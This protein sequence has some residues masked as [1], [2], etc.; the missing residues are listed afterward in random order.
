MITVHHG[1]VKNEKFDIDRI[2]EEN[3]K[4]SNNV[5]VRK[6]DVKVET[7][8]SDNLYAGATLSS[9]TDFTVDSDSMPTLSNFIDTTKLPL[10]TSEAN[11][12]LLTTTAKSLDEPKKHTVIPENKIYDDD[13]DDSF[14]DFSVEFSGVKYVR[15][16]KFRVHTSYQ[17]TALTKPLV[18]GFLATVGYPKFY[19][20]DSECNWKISAPNGQKIRLTILDLNLRSESVLFFVWFY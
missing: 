16:N 4:K 9:K 15:K 19:V 13:E 5:I 1:I 7:S 2:I 6:P 10:T 17:M 18:Q 20:G 11:Q 12:F 8:S 3:N 14:E